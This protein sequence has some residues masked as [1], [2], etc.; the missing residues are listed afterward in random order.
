[1]NK[2]ISA[3]GLAA[4][5]LVAAP[6]MAADGGKVKKAKTTKTVKAADQLTVDTKASK[7][8]WI[9]EK[10]TGKHNGNLMLQNGTV[11]A[12]GGRLT[13]GTFTFDMTSITVE[14]LKDAEYNGKLL[15]H[16]K[17]DDFFSVE[18]NPTSTFKITSVAPIKGAKAGAANYTVTGDLSI[19][20]I[21]NRVTFPATV[22][23]AGSQ[24]T[25]IGTLKVDRTK[26]DIKYG[27]GS[28]FDNLGDKAISNDMT[29]S[30]N[31]VAKK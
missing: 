20:G 1:M 15:G 14:D 17:S 9:G 7:V 6:V 16:L 3:L 23:M 29:I 12:N 10:V 13:G 26:Y 5:L 24:L 27:S 11:E 21:T 28:F 25:A 4:A 2:M 19:K 18:K 22:T 31:V 8:E 30:F